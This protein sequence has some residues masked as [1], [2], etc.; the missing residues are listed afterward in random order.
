MSKDAYWFTHDANARNDTKMIRLRR[1]AGLE[2]V[3]FYW[4]IIE[5]LRE[6]EKHKLTEVEID[7]LAYEMRCKNDN[8]LSEIVECELLCSDNSDFYF[9]PS[10]L[11]RLKKWNEK[12]KK[13]SMAGR[14]GGI[15]SGAKRKSRSKRS[16][17]VKQTL[18]K[19]EAKPKQTSSKTKLEENRIEQNRIEQNKT[20]Q[21]MSIDKAPKGTSPTKKKSK[22]GETW[23]A[24]SEAYKKHYR[25]DPVRNA[26]SNALCA[27]LVD[28]LGSDIAPGV[29]AFF[30]TLNSQYYVGRGHSLQSLVADAEKVCTEWKTGRVMTGQKARQ[31]ERTSTNMDEWNELAIEMTG[32]DINGNPVKEEIDG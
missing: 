8:I 11:N 25:T 13:R 21:I 2:G 16:P 15:A 32:M 4:C 17:N 3:G 23:N 1:K 29:A 6:T 28:R 18:S 20:E 9:S 26:K 31:Q 27:Q 14:A 19:G 5:L 12:K 22:G 24:Y 7:D 30:L 10:L